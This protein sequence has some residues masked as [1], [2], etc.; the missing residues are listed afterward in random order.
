M[1][2][3]KKIN[4]N[5]DN[6]LEHNYVTITMIIYMSIINHNNDNIAYMNIY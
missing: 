6:V 5:N 3:W 2:A 4:L 1:H